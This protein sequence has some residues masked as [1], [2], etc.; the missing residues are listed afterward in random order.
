MGKIFAVTLVRAC[1][2]IEISNEL[3]DYTGDQPYSVAPSLI[4]TNLIWMYHMGTVTPIA[5]VQ[6]RSPLGGMW[7]VL[8]SPS[9]HA[10]SHRGFRPSCRACRVRE[11]YHAAREAL[12]E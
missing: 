11:Y 9:E 12:T 7:D 4:L 10:L 6:G 1:T 3:A 2:A 5:L 8:W